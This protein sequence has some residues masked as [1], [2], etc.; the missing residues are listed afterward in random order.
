[1]THEGLEQG[2][3]PSGELDRSSIDPH[4]SRMQVEGD[5]SVGDH[6]RFCLIRRAETSS[7]SGEDLLPADRRQEKIEDDEVELGRPHESQA[8]GPVAS[9]P[10]DEAL[11][12]KPPLD[13][14]GDRGFVLND[15][16]I[17]GHRST[18]RDRPKKPLPA[19]PW[20]QSCYRVWSATD[21]P[22]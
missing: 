18:P 1:M 5:G 15:Q 9:G 2:K 13:E 6:C 19:L 7:D 14:G 20:V 21:I 12:F 4:L 8:L 16:H 22:A 11:C 10:D 17:H 3:L